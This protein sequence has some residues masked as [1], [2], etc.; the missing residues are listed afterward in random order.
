[1]TSERVQVSVSP[2]GLVSSVAKSRAP[3]PPTSRPGIPPPTASGTSPQALA[4]PPSSA[5]CSTR[6]LA[7]AAW[8]GASLCSP[9]GCSTPGR[10]WRGPGRSGSSD[11]GGAVRGKT[12]SEDLARLRIFSS[13]ETG[14]YFPEDFYFDSAAADAFFLADQWRVFSK[15]LLKLRA[16][17]EMLVALRF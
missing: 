15:V 8:P 9:F 13:V 5:E 2:P 1:M 16:S 7:R 11:N 12:R 10:R 17:Q 3:S 6:S 14:G 4:L